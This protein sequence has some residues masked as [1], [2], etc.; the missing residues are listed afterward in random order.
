MRLFWQSQGTFVNQALIGSHFRISVSV[1][2]VLRFPFHRFPLARKVTLYLLYKHFSI[3]RFVS[4]LHNM[5]TAQFIYDSIQ[6]LE[7]RDSRPFCKLLGRAWAR[8]TV[9][10]WM[11]ILCNHAFGMCPQGIIHMRQPPCELVWGDYVFYGTNT[12]TQNDGSSRKNT[13]NRMWI[14]S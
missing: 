12:A 7:L 6:L 3:T 14:K 1:L 13:R 10:M 4:S 5:F 11:V 2:P 9:V 8:P